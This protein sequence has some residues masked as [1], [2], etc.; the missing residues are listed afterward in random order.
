MKMAKSAHPLIYL[1]IHEVI[2]RLISSRK[3]INAG[4]IITYEFYYVLQNFDQL[5][6]FWQN[7]L[8]VAGVGVLI[9]CTSCTSRLA[10]I[11]AYSILSNLSDHL[12]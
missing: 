12:L 2:H 10:F 8:G 7:L 5:F 4:P 6:R 1:Q 9:A 3:K 11:C